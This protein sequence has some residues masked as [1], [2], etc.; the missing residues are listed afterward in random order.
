MMS[1][2]PKQGLK[3]GSFLSLLSSG[4]GGIE[5]NTGAFGN[6]R[7]FQTVDNLFIDTKIEL[8]KM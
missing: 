7:R 2:P 6:H 8:I 1:I 3:S 5:L 4:S